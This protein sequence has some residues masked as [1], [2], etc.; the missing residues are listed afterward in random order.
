VLASYPSLPGTA[1]ASAKTAPIRSAGFEFQELNLF[2]RT[3]NEHS[4]LL[5]Y[6]FRFC[7]SATKQMA[8]D[9]IRYRDHTKLDYV[10]PFND[11]TV[12]RIEKIAIFVAVLA[13]L[14]GVL[15]FSL[16]PAAKS[17]DA[18]VS[19]VQ[20]FDGY[21]C[22]MISSVTRIIEIYSFSPTAVDSGT[23]PFQDS[24]ANVSDFNSQVAA[25]AVS[26]SF[27]GLVLNNRQPA[28]QT[29]WS[30]QVPNSVGTPTNQL[31]YLNLHFDSYADC[32]AAARGQTACRLQSEK[33]I[34]YLTTRDPS[35]PKATECAADIRCSS[36][37][38][39]AVYLGNL[40][41]MVNRTVLGD[42]EFGQCNNEANVSACQNILSNCESLK[43]FVAGYDEIFR[44]IVLTPELLCQPL[45]DNPPYVCTKAVSPSVPSICRNHLLSQLLH[46][47]L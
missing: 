4:Y 43:R 30:F 17:N 34:V 27:N 9:T 23:I 35:G 41:I 10:P 20:L 8:S 29:P 32:L 31:K 25:L 13:G 33:A 40:Q 15:Y 7:H 1:A 24:L 16:A 44:K 37:N 28:V 22:K 26:Q 36:L 14:F 2:L 6:S 38:G 47:Q 46:W 11:A 18:K 12:A 42:P 45:F 39:K 3:I 5:S 21:N 19:S